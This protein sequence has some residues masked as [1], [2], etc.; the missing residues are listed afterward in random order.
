MKLKRVWAVIAVALMATWA[1][2]PVSAAIVIVATATVSQP[3]ESC[4]TIAMG[5]SSVSVSQTSH[6]SYT[7]TGGSANQQLSVAENFTLDC[8]GTSAGTGGFDPVAVQLNAM[9]EFSS[10]QITVGGGQLS[11]TEGG[12]TTT[13]FSSVSNKN[14]PEGDTDTGTKIFCVTR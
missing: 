11:L 3:S 12:Y 10:G 1:A 7:I 2:G 5:Q 6:H 14:G 13:A 9:G 8:N 4:Y